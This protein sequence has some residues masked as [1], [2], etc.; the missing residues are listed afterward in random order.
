MLT[1]GV[2]VDPIHCAD[3]ETEAHIEPSAGKGESEASGWGAVALCVEPLTFTVLPQ[4]CAESLFSTRVCW[5]L[6]AACEYALSHPTQTPAL[7]SP[8]P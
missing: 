2:C 5:S 4:F 6:C 7:L 1:C 8:L 3:E